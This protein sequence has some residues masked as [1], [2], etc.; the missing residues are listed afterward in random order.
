MFIYVLILTTTLFKI[1]KRISLYLI[2]RYMNKENAYILNV[3]LFNHK[4]KYINCR[5]RMGLKGIRATEISEIN[6]VSYLL[7]HVDFE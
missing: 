4:N 3:D 7:S 2:S 1:V 6:K 5:Q